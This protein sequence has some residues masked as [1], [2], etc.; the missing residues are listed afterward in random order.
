MGIFGVPNPR[1]QTFGKK[2]QDFVNLVPFLEMT[3]SKLGILVDLVFQQ[4][5]AHD[6]MGACF[7][8]GWGVV[9]VGEVMRCDDGIPLNTQEI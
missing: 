6:F 3:L 9:G 2:R 4:L 8:S 5:E 7:R 1:D